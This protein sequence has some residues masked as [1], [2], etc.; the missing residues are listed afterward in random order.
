MLTP[1]EARDHP[2]ASLLYRAIGQ[3]PHIEVDI[4]P[5]LQL[6]ESDGILLCSDGLCGYVDDGEIEAV[7]RSRVTVQEVADRLIELALAK[8]G[9]DNISVQFIQ[10]SE[11]IEAQRRYKHFLYQITTAVIVMTLLTGLLYVGFQH[12]Q[13]DME[14]T[15]PVPSDEHCSG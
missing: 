4:S 8:G 6:K 5:G 2:Q 12:L 13:K 7:L 14:G 10:Y 3:K 15:Q 1:A 11:R 9:Q